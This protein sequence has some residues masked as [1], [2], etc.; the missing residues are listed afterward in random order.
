MNTEFDNKTE[1][2]KTPIE[3]KKFKTAL[4]VKQKNIAVLC[5]ISV[6]FLRAVD[7]THDNIT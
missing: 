2:L 3:S 7:S 4:Q 6:L 5:L 1:I